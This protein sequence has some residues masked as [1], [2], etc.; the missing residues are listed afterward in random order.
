[1]SREHLLKPVTSGVT[2]C[3]VPVY[4]VLSIREIEGV[5]M[6]YCDLHVHSIRSS[7]GFHTVLE[8]A[9]I[10]RDKGKEAF[11]LTDHGPALK[12][13]RSHFSVLMRRLPKVI[14]GVRVFKGIESSILDT[15]GTI[16][17]PIWEGTSYEVIL[18]GLH[19]HDHFENSRTVSDHTKATIAA[20][21]RNP[22]IK[23]ITHPYHNL[24]PIDLDAIT[25][26]A[27]ETGTALEINNSHLLMHKADSDQLSRMLE[28][29]KAKGTL[30][31]VNSDGH[32]FS[33]MGEFDHA[34]A[35]LEPFGI[36]SFTIVN[37]SFES[38]LEFL[39]L[40]G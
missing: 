29:V 13:P 6:S 37:R 14:K 32:V 4:D 1:V 20:M 38:T 27:T 34:L 8:I 9:D 5:Y 12:T 17:L 10:M 26:V 31:A 16:D 15:E 22:A 19:P 21:R 40:A 33:E 28:L 7:C 39:G 25:D 18:A 23:I 11:A 24:Y 3:V 2:G 35:A 36:D 30:L